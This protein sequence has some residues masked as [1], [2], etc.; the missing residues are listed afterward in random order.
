MS[1]TGLSFNSAQLD[2]DH[3]TD[4]QVRSSLLPLA[5]APAT[6][7]WCPALALRARSRFHLR[8]C[9]SVQ[10]HELGVV[11]QESTGRKLQR[12]DTVVALISDHQLC[13]V[14]FGVSS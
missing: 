14:G 4:Y 9:T 10:A 7:N 3:I 11:E 1:C 13:Q 2:R 8:D 12:H 5:T 6:T